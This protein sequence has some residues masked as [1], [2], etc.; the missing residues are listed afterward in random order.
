MILIVLALILI[1]VGAYLVNGRDILAPGVLFSFSFLFSSVW[2]LFFSKSWGLSPEKNTIYVIVLGTFEFVLICFIVSLVYDKN[3]LKE[4]NQERP[5]VVKVSKGKLLFI[6]FLEIIVIVYIIRALKQA[7]GVENL[8]EAIYTYRRTNLFYSTT[9]TLPKSVYL[10]SYF[11]NS[12]GFYF[13][14]LFVKNVIDKKKPD[15]LM[16]ICILLSGYASTLFGARTGLIVLILAGIAYYFC[17]YRADTGNSIFVQPKVFVIGTSVLAL[18]LYNF[19]VF[20]NLLGRQVSSAS[21]QY[22][23]EYAGAEIKNLDTFVRS[24]NFPITTDAFHMQTLRYV[25]KMLGFL[26][27]V[28]TN[29]KLD[30]P[31]Q[32]YNGISLGNVYTTY[33][34]FLYDLG[35]FGVFIFVLFM[36]IIVQ[37]T[38]MKTKI[39]RDRGKV[40]YSILIYGYMVNTLVLAFF[41]NKF[42]EQIF[43]SSFFYM[44]FFWWVLDLFVHL[45]LYAND[46]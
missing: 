32:Y 20:A 5:S 18:F 15:I 26:F 33:Y 4:K 28:N 34:Q 46:K 41:S 42:Y 19:K 12:I 8:S 29:Y 27:G 24:G 43:T 3:T 21:I 37:Y 10:A 9:I 14:Y 35:Y 30:L 11:C 22:I 6:I 44:I 2:A 7:T 31:F 45:N 25:S 16:A 36:A 38:Y 1:F 23:A 39:F 13:L 17:L 40:S